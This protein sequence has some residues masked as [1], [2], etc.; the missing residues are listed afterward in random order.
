MLK[1]IFSNIYTKHI[2]VK[3]STLPLP[4]KPGEKFSAWAQ[5]VQRRLIQASGNTDWA[6]PRSHALVFRYRN[7][8]LTYESNFLNRY[9]FVETSKA[10]QSWLKCYE[11]FIPTKH[12]FR[13][14]EGFLSLLKSK[15]VSVL[16]E[17]IEEHRQFS[18]QLVM[19]C[20]FV[21]N[22]EKIEYYAG[23]KMKNVLNV[24]DLETTLDAQIAT[25]CYN[26][27]KN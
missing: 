4:Q 14:P 1:I 2:D 16:N 26:L 12:N 6:F 7:H 27:D 10:F 9:H 23:D 19:R 15:I 5:R 17:V 8:I 11:L 24:D 22:A 3:M 18:F 13:D 25:N 21:R 20:N